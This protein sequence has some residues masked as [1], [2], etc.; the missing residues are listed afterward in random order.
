L[1]ISWFETY[2]EFGIAIGHP[3]VMALCLVGLVSN[4]SAIE[5][6]CFIA[7]E[8]RNREKKAKEEAKNS[9]AKS[10]VLDE[11]ASGSSVEHRV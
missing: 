10:E 3:M 5:R 8:I 7:K 6:L 1:T 2:R 4:V 9:L 11:E